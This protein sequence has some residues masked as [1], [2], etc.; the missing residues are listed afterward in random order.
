MKPFINYQHLEG[1]PMTDRN[2]KEKNSRFWNK[3]KWDTFIAPLLPKDCSEMTLVDVGCNLG[4]FCK[5]AKD[6]GFKK[7]V[8]VEP[9]NAVYEKAIAYRDKHGYDYEIINSKI[10]DCAK[11][12]PLADVV[13]MSNSHYY[14]VISEWL[15]YVDDLKR[16]ACYCLVVTKDS[17]DVFWKPLTS[18]PHFR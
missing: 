7:V 2:K 8:G 14:I 17:R 18:P 3:G 13:L 11:D 1:E 12:L 4:L 5:L 10:E 16:K 9:E 6:H 15:D